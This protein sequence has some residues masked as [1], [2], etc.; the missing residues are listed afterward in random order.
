MPGHKALSVRAK[1][2][3]RLAKPARGILTT[4]RAR[5]VEDRRAEETL[6]WVSRTA[7]HPP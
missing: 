2:L 1:V 4:S 3:L 7:S 6:H 5:L